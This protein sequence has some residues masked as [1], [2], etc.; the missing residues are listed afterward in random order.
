M[1]YYFV[2]IFVNTCNSRDIGWCRH[3]INDSIQKF[4]NTFVSVSSTT[5]YRNCLTFAGSFTQCS[6]QCVDG[7]FFTFQIFHHQV[8][9]QLAD[10]LDQF[11]MIQ[12]CI[13]FHIFRDI[14]D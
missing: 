6:F 11:C 4:L 13:V 7:W 5:A 8:I 2:A 12:F 9:I 3:E 14:C 10:F 1:S